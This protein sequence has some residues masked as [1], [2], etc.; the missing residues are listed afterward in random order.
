MTKKLWKAKSKIKLNSHLYNFEK[1]ISKKFKQ[2]FDKKYNKILNWSIKNSGEF[3]SSVW[4]FCKV[5]GIKGRNKIKKSK[6]FYKNIFLPNSKVN[7]AENLLSKKNNSKAI[8]FVSENGFREERSWKNL[9]NNVGKLQD[10]FKKIGLIK[11]DRVA[12]YMINSIETVETFIAT[13]SI[14]AIW[15]SC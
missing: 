11:R 1:Y 15:S 6:I 14:G 10:F 3:W 12:A 5:K 8:T 2:N 7:F 13:S 4:D 9:N